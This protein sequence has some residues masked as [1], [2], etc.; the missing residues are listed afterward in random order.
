MKWFKHEADARNSLKLRK[1]RRRYGSDG[2]A[3]YW[4]CLEAIAY[5]IDKDNLTFE[6]K[7]DAETI[8]FELSIQESRVIE[9]MQ[10]MVKI[11]LFESS[12][13]I[14]TCLKLAER[15]DKSMTNSPKLRKWLGEKTVMTLPDN[16]SP[17]D[18]DVNTCHELDKEVD[19]KRKEKNINNKKPK[20]CPVEFVLNEFQDSRLNLDAWKEWCE[21]RAKDKKKPITETTA[22][23]QITL[24]VKYNV[25]DQ[26]VIIDKSIN[27]SYQGLF[28]LPKS[29][30]PVGSVDQA[31]DCDF[32]DFETYS[33]KYT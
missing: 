24:L 26:R 25:D 5:D 28:D 30:L 9:I 10:Y 23:K 3:I 16:V 32:M 7:E 21:F 20:F 22:K 27:G 19:K 2:Y 33:E 14:I 18:D 1:V 4:F 8:A 6:L 11:G 17:I 29:K 31:G 12:N 13:N 15:L